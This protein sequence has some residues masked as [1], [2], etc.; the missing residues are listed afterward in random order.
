MCS[1]LKKMKQNKIKKQ[2][3]VKVRDW[4]LYDSVLPCIYDNPDY[5]EFVCGCY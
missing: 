2:K 3:T 4:K 1:N 5:G